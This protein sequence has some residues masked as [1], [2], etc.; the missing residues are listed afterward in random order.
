MY[1]S[2]QFCMV[3]K[4]SYGFEMFGMSHFSLQKD[5]HKGLLCR[6][7]TNIIYNINSNIIIILEKEIEETQVICYS[8]HVALEMVCA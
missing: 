5:K 6:S 7:I 8:V 4:V 3:W 2:L 1:H